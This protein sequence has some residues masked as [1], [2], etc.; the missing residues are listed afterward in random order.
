M[1]VSVSEARFEERRNKG[2]NTAK[3]KKGSPSRSGR[4]PEPHSW[5]G[6]S[7]ELAAEAEAEDEVCSVQTPTSF[8]YLHD[9][10][11]AIIIVLY[12]HNK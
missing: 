8:T 10:P 4:F 7:A 9:S 5:A 2:R 6:K 11:L 1:F 12:L 3:K